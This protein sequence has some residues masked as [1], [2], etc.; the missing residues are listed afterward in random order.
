MDLI[1]AVKMRKSIRGFKPD[2]VSREIIT[3]VLSIA[4]QAPSGSNTQPWEFAVVTGDVLEKIKQGNIE[5]FRSGAPSRQ[6]RKVTE[7][8]AD[9]VYQRR[10]A[11]LTKQLFALMDI[12]R[13]DAAKRKAWREKGIRFFDAPAAIIVLNDR[14]LPE[15]G[16][17][18]DMGIVIQTIC[19]TAMTY[20]LGTCIEGQGT[21]YPDVIR[22][23]A[24]IP[25]SKR[26]VIAIAV[27]YP[28]P[29]DPANRIES[30]REPIN[31]ITTWH[32]FE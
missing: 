12:Q 14:L 16:P 19:L 15:P 10:R 20:G 31:N 1:E 2:P 27:G 6:E 4:N 18:L 25:D 8:P 13:E 28:D 30:S 26:I 29:D 7:K 11:E 22:K 21:M 24:N 32:G 23:Y 5:M 9:T 17:L 3:E